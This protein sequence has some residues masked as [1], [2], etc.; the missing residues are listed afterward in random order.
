MSNNNVFPALSQIGERIN[1]RVDIQKGTLSWASKT[2]EKQKENPKIINATIGTAKNDDGTILVSKTLHKEICSLSLDEMFGYGKI[3]G[4]PAF[5]SG[6][7]ADTINM[8]P[9]DLQ[10][11][12]RRNTSDPIPVA[13]GLTNGLFLTGLIMLNPGDI[14][15]TPDARWENVDNL[16]YGNLG[17]KLI[18]FPF[19][20][21][22]N[23][24]N[25]AGLKQAL[26]KARNEEKKV[27]LY[28]N[29]PNNPTGYM[30]S[31]DETELLGKFLEN[32]NE[33]LIVLLDDAYEGYVYLNNEESSSQPLDCS[34]FPYLLSQNENVMLFKIDAPTKRR[35]M[36]GF[37]L[38]AISYGP[39][40]KSFKETNIRQVLA[41]AV[42]STISSAPRPPQE[43]L[44]RIF[45]DQKK[46]NSILDD[47]EQIRRK[48]EYRHQKMTLKEKTMPSLHSLKPMPANS[49][50]FHFYF[51]EGIDAQ[52][53]GEKLL[54]NG[55]G[56][57]PVTNQSGLNGIR[58]AHCGIPSNM[59]EKSIDI[60]WDTVKG[61][62]N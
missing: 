38:G 13:G 44:A 15:I 29:F 8:Y 47:V 59:I 49:S 41:K 62:E 12:A 35:P 27:A 3:A 7:K 24:F 5:I 39:P 33:D 45:S 18:D 17:L 48:L 57:V 30:V 28:L 58:L 53:L 22:R 23:E 4:M 34:V 16:F 54:E 2:I 14:I 42:R 46:Y 43:A 56:V 60:L 36:Y 61:F 31:K 37:R 32:Q 55:L 9:E 11:F 50:F 26:N 51:V 25:L 20:N 1:Q 52:I 40:L 10:L 19:F 6:W 21:E